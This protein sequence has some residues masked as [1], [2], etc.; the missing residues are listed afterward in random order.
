MNWPNKKKWTR[1]VDTQQCDWTEEKTLT[2]REEV[3]AENHGAHC[4]CGRAAVRA[5]QLL[6]KIELKSGAEKTLEGL[7]R[8]RAR[9][10]AAFQTWELFAKLSRTR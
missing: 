9:P 6:H 2:R 7:A 3:T 10:H 4:V 1:T 5:K 8:E